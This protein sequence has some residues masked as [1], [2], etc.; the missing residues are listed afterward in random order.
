MKLQTN[1]ATQQVPQYHPLL[2]SLPMV[3]LGTAGDVD[4]KIAEAVC[5][6]TKDC[7]VRLIDTAQN[8]GSE[9]G[10]GRGL[11]ES[12]IT[13]EADGLFISTKVDLASAT[14]EDPAE[15]VRRQVKGSMTK[16]G[17]KYLDSVVIHW[18]ICLDKPCTEDEHAAA[19][20]GCWKEL[21]A[22]VAEG[23]IGVIGTSN[24]TVALLDELL[25]FAQIKPSI[26][27]IEVSPACP[28]TEIV[29]YCANKGIIVVGYSPYG[30]CWI[31][32]DWESLVPWAYANL[33][34]NDTV[35]SVATEASYTPAQVL[36]RW[37]VQR[38]IVPIPKS[39][40]A[41]RIS[42][43]LATLD[44]K[45]SLTS[46]QMAKIDTLEDPQRGVV[47]SIDAHHKVMA[48]PDFTW[49]PT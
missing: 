16:L 29:D 48:H 40:K 45:F 47:A 13:Q 22:L 5:A 33:I 11:K 4:G 25:E 31:A 43:S 30:G 41:T 2:S 10:I 23:L 24:W 46:E 39:V 12:G 34:F 21:E 18:P 17:V 9:P 15:R 42:E 32:A 27:Q 19:R 35:K 26:N 49:T 7:G 28:Q 20:R 8:Y 14:H 38:G 44:N 37:S 36:L 3:G 1:V 6:A